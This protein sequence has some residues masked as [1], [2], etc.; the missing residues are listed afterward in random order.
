MGFVK[1]ALIGD[2]KRWM[3][4]SWNPGGGAKQQLN[5]R[6]SRTEKGPTEKNALLVEQVV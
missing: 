6:K 2:K 1:P 3:A 4:A 5:T